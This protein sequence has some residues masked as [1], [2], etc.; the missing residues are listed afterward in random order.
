MRETVQRQKGCG[1]ESI[2]RDFTNVVPS[3]ERNKGSENVDAEKR[4]VFEAFVRVKRN[5]LK[6]DTTEQKT[7]GVSN[8]VDRKEKV[9]FVPTR[10]KN[11]TRFFN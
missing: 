7:R 4:N 2:P 6:N 11:V 10:G 1:N 3:R 5:N 8:T 9:L